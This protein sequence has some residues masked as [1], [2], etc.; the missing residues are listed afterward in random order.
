[1]GTRTFTVFGKQ[2]MSLNL[3][4]AGPSSF[5]NLGARP[6]NPRSRRRAPARGPRRRPR[7]AARSQFRPVSASA[8]LSPRSRLPHVVLRCPM[9]HSA[10]PI[11]RPAGEL[12]TRM[13]GGTGAPGRREVARVAYAPRGARTA[14][15]CGCALHEMPRVGALSA[16][17]RDGAVHFPRAYQRR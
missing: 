14:D 16:L 13:G 3:A 5:A 9:Q 10:L 2:T 4:A 11:R 1:M 7:F 12:G 8:P 15:D 6:S 17:S